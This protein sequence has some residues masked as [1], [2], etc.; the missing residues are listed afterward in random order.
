MAA[1]GNKHLS[2]RTFH[3]RRRMLGQLMTFVL[4]I[5]IVILC[6]HVLSN[7]CAIEEAF[8]VGT[9]HHHVMRRAI[10]GGAVTS[11]NNVT[12]HCNTT[13]LPQ[14][15]KEY[16]AI[17][18]KDVNYNNCTSSG[19]Y[20]KIRSGH[21]HTWCKNDNLKR[22]R[23]MRFSSMLVLPGYNITF[24]ACC[25]SGNKWHRMVSDV[26]S[27]PDLNNTVFYHNKLGG[28][29]GIW[30]TS[31]LH[32]DTSFFLMIGGNNLNSSSASD[33]NCGACYFGMCSATG[34]CECA[35]GY[36]GSDCSTR[37]S[38]LTYPSQEY[39]LVLFP[40]TNF[41]GTPVRAK[42]D[43]FK[44]FAANRRYAREIYY[45]SFRVLYNRT[46]TF[47]RNIVYP[48]NFYN[49]LDIEDVVEFMSA[50]SETA[51]KI[52]YSYATSIEAD[53]GVKV[54]GNA[55][56]DNCSISTGVCYTGQCKCMP[57]FTGA[58]CDT[59]V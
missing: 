45:K 28:N 16:P 24:K 36:S 42:P 18:F 17:L 14:P 27:T 51:N 5:L 13:A 52:W 48:E 44:T 21:Y 3:S 58:N 37:P 29:A 23:N 49:G 30:Y 34:K 53:F 4:N 22:R 15:T 57:G 56:C 59:S 35:P 20:I 33:S 43:E 39:P 8:N 26:S 11:S 7:S 25:P 9:G 19:V 41:A 2:I 46:I 12:Y 40:G 54:G 6:F 38:T 50:N 32:W 1:K 47:A 10:G 55:A 31:W